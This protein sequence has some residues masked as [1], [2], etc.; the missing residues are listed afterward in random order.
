MQHDDDTRIVTLK[1]AAAAV[2]DPRSA[3]KALRGE[4]V[5]GLAGDRIKRAM[6]ELGVGGQ[7]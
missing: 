4:A 1:I 2:V 3:A 6:R 5:K 7:S